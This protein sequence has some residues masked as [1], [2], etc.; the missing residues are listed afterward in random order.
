M[1]RISRV[2]YVLCW[3]IICR[4]EERG[5][6][7]RDGWR[8]GGRVRERVCV[9]V[10]VC[11]VLV[12]PSSNL[13]RV[14]HLAIL[15]I[16][17]DGRCRWL[18][19]GVLY[20]TAGTAIPSLGLEVMSAD[21]SLAQI[22]HTVPW[23]HTHTM[24]TPDPAP[25]PVPDLVPFGKT[26]LPGQSQAFERA[27]GIGQAARRQCHGAGAGCPICGRE[28][29]LPSS[30]SQPVQPIAA[31]TRRA[32]LAGYGWQV[33]RLG[34]AAM[35]EAQF[36]L[37]CLCAARP[38]RRAVLQT[39]L[40]HRTAS[41]LPDN[42]QPAWVPPRT[43]NP[44]WE[45]PL[46]QNP[47]GNVIRLS[48]HWGTHGPVQGGSCRG[49]TL[50]LGSDLFLAATERHDPFCRCRFIICSGPWTWPGRAVTCV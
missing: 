26:N 47:P 27:A 36:A 13:G 33:C 46:M 24:T 50:Q 45:F 38:S 15:A 22:D 10:C 20:R 6:G 49:T 25:G 39:A 2:A 42:R 37:S 4:I 23:G 28:H 9:C 7:C 48:N 21:P 19:G 43:R 31:C 30:P 34:R 41:A 1:M 3:T 17:P 32:P 14:C 5:C 40:K 12:D 44:I 35:G 16:S 8:P 29:C 11:F 18:V